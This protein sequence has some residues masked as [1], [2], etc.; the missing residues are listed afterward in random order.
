MQNKPGASTSLG[1]NGLERDIDCA[2]RSDVNVLI[3]GGDD[4]T[5]LA[6][7][8]VLHQRTRRMDEPFVVM[9]RDRMS[10]VREGWEFPPGGTLF[11]EEV[12]D[13]S[14]TLQTALVVLLD[15]RS[16]QSKGG[17]VQHVRGTRVVAAT[18]YNLFERI[19]QQ[20]FREDLFYRLNAIHVVL[21]EHD[22]FDVLPG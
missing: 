12:G 3:S 18:T 10:E 16:A 20:R 7:A 19:A 6:L 2:I 11:I 14:P 22:I 13:L 21:P 1:Y 17:R 15:R 9:E 8:H 5:R 4:R